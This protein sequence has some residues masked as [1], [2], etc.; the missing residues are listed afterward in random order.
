MSEVQ[1]QMALV[2]P[3]DDIQVWNHGGMI[4]TGENGRTRRKTCPSVTMSTHKCHTD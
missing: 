1:P 3:P 2:H 4:L